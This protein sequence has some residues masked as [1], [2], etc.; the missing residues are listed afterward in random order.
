MNIEQ[1]QVSGC[2]SHVRLNR[3][4]HTIIQMAHALARANQKLEAEQEYNKVVFQ[5]RLAMYKENEALKINIDE[6]GEMIT[7]RNE[8][9]ISKEK[10]DSESR[11]ENRLNVRDY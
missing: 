11:P 2:E 4:E 9:I 3:E 1:K 10:N 8:E 5:Q 7:Q 6:L